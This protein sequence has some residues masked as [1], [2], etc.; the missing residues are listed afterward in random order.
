MRPVTSIPAELRADC[1]NCA[2]L[3][4]VALPFTTSAEFAIDKPADAPCPNLAGDFTCGIHA[5][6]R[7][8]GFSGCTSF[9]CFGAGQKVTQV[10][11]RG[12]EWRSSPEIA[13]TMFEAFRRMRQ[14]HEL[15]RLLAEASSTAA[16]GPVHGM[17]RLAYDDLEL[18]SHGD[19][20]AILELDL[21]AHRQGIGAV[22]EIVSSIVRTADGELGPDHSR[23]T[24][25]GAR[26]R[27]ADLRRA[28]LRAALL[29]GADL[30]DAD[31]R[32]ADLLGTDLRGARLEGAD[33]TDALF[34][35]QPQIDGARGDARTRLP[36]TV[37]RPGHW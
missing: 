23:A 34:L 18:R 11:F 20:T 25:I 37:E 10:T 13:A 22:L 9:D 2:G 6:L 16:A 29:V 8:R 33:L 21:D 5:E 35:T 1:A 12:A 27:G 24:L 19:R 15:L 7:P 28:D 26:F 17:V 14:V 32:V 36:Q 4:C 31:L 30:R 3:C